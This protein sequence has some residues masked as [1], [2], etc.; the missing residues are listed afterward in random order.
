M[1]KNYFICTFFTLMLVISLGC[2]VSGTNNPSEPDV[3][4]YAIG[5]TGPGGGIVFYITDNGIHGLEAATSDQDSAI[6][7]QGATN[8]SSLV[9]T[10][11]GLNSGSANT[12]AIIALAATGGYTPSQFAAGIARSYNGGGYTDWFLPSVDELVEL[13]KQKDVVGSFFNNYYWSS[14]EDGP[15]EAK[16]LD[17]TGNTNSPDYSEKSHLCRVRAIRAF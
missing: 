5:D 4:K 17:F 13:Y 15:T 3:S 16:T 10:L 1:K 11:Y 8:Q 12:D 2:N 14:S 7:I 9:N 6:W